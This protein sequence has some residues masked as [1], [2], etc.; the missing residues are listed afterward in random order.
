MTVTLKDIQREK[1][2]CRINIKCS[3]QTDRH[4]QS[5][6]GLHLSS[7]L[8]LM[9]MIVSQF[10]IPKESDKIFLTLHGKINQNTSTLCRR[11]GSLPYP[12]IIFHLP[13]R[14]LQL[15]SIYFLG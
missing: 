9:S 12:A 15:H 3:K 6:F 8:N 14:H 11:K 5:S 2:L 4:I 13:S 1:P 10:Y 7:K